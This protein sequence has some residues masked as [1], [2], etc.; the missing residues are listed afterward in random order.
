MVMRLRLLLVSTPEVLPIGLMGL[1]SRDA[2]DVDHTFGC[3]AALAS[4]EVAAPDAMIIDCPGGAAPDGTDAL[5]VVV[6]RAEAE[7]AAIILL[8]DKIPDWPLPEWVQFAPRDTG[9]DE[10]WGRVVSLCHGRQLAHNT[11]RDLRDLQRLGRHINDQFEEQGRDM[12]LASNLQRKFLPRGLPDLPGVRFSVIYRPAS[13]V[14]GDIYDVARIDERNLCMYIA[15][16]VGH[17]VAASLLTIFVKRAVISKEITSSG[18]R[19]L[20]P[21][22]TLELINTA[23]VEADLECSQFVT[24]TYFMYNLADQTVQ[25]ARA[26]H[27]YPLLVDEEGQIQELRSDGSLLGLMMD[28]KF[29]LGS[30]KLKPGQKLILYS[31]GMDEAFCDNDGGLATPKFM[32]S[33]ARVAHLP[34]GQVTREVEHM[35]DAEQ[36]SLNP[37]DD[38]TMVVLEATPL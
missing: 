15:D 11:Q 18:Y 21:N 2:L 26:G 30:C 32:R 35:L 3:E 10:L 8:V 12:R 17:G 23:L 34:A 28:Q 38:V 16:C 37:K 33:L 19:I 9:E 14:S 36:G 5:T 31:D 24:A 1:S 6:D 22:E 13:W 25:F 27:P 7:A 20:P 29:E 4:F